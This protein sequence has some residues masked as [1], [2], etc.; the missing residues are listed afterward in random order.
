LT[1][2]DSKIFLNIVDGLN[3]RSKNDENLLTKQPR[4][5]KLQT[6]LGIFAKNNIDFCQKII[7]WGQNV[8]AK[9]SKIVRILIF[10]QNI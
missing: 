1:F 7:V 4:L 6:F 3:C 5:T 10:L 2:S 8:V 9:Q